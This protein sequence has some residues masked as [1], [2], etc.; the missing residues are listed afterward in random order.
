VLQQDSITPMTGDEIHHLITAWKRH[1]RP[2]EGR[3]AKR[4]PLRHPKVSDEAKRLAESASPAPRKV[5]AAVDSSTN[6]GNARKS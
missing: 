4:V 3:V 1:P 5:K 6:M 2:D